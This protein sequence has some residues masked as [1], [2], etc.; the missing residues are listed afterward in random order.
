MKFL[1]K[2]NHI[3]FFVLL[4]TMLIFFSVTAF[5][6]SF[7]EHK[8]TGTISPRFTFN[9]VYFCEEWSFNIG[10]YNFFLPEES[11]VIP[12]YYKE[13]FCGI[14]IYKNNNSL[15]VSK[16]AIDYKVSS[17]FLS[18][19]YDTFLQ[20]KGDTLF[21]PLEDA[22]Y[23][24]K[25]LSFVAQQ[26]KFPEMKGIGFTQ[27]FLPPSDSYYIHLENGIVQHDFTLPYLE[28]NFIWCLLYFGSVFLIIILVIQ[29]LTM[30]LQPSGKLLHLLENTPPTWQE[31]LIT[32]GLLS[33][34]LIA[35]NLS[36]SLPF[37]NLIYPTKMAS[38]Y[39]IGIALYIFSRKQIITLPKIALNGQHLDRCII[40]ALVVSF[41]ITA[42]S[43]FKF[44]SGIA[45]E[46]TYTELAFYF[47][48]YFFYALGQEFF[49]RAYLQTFLERLWGKWSG[50]ILTPLTVSAVFFLTLL[51]RYS[52]M[53]HSAQDLWQ[54]FFFVPLTSFILGYTYYRSRNI[55][56]STLL[57]ALLLFLPRFLT[58]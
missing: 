27:V 14:V 2:F 42:F 38:Y 24:K 19:N 15:T 3:T 4:L 57:H 1:F 50:L 35:E 52:G 29:I 26:I 10:E 36:P 32:L 9:E 33:A 30:D 12:V 45:P 53:P 43:A 40:I 34:V 22:Y 17:G 21:M 49:W 48:L 11:M 13:D 8:C 23:K 25:L 6:I 41:I 7:S 20:L 18:T 44:P 28:K 46:L 51:Y 16:G 58:F 47:F 31:L 56:S 37:D 39:I 55:F 5:W 54:L